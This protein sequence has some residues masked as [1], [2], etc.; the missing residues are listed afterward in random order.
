MIKRDLRQEIQANIDVLKTFNKAD[1]VEIHI[2]EEHILDSAKNIIKK[3]QKKLM[4]LDKS[5]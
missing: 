1:M 4:E 3:L 2:G 5:K